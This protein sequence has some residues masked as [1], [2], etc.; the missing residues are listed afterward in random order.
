M[1]YVPVEFDPKSENTQHSILTSYRTVFENKCHHHINHF[2]M[3]SSS[4]TPRMRSSMDS[5]KTPF[6][7]ADNEETAMLTPAEK[8]RIQSSSARQ[9]RFLKL[10]III[11]AGLLLL[12]TLVDWSNVLHCD[13]SYSTGPPTHSVGGGS[14][15]DATTASP[16]PNCKYGRCCCG[17]W[18]HTHSVVLRL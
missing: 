14:G 18:N 11:L 9:D 2:N 5:F 13:C 6:L 10:I 3:A 16:L 8:D 12:R 1:Q 4:D 17:I 7:S 15:K